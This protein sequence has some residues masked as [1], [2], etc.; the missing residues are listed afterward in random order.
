MDTTAAALPG[1]S[2]APSRV[3]AGRTQCAVVGGG[4]LG[5]ALAAALRGSGRSVSGPHGRGADVADADVVVLCVPDAAI[6][7]AA[8]AARAS[9]PVALLVHCS[10]ATG[11]AALGADGPRGSL[12]PLVGVPAGTGPEGLAG[13]PCAV[14]GSGDAELALLRELAG[15]IG[16]R[17]FAVADEDRAAYH[18]AASMAAN[19]LVTLEGAAERL[20]GTAGVGRERLV[21]LVR[22]AVE[23]WAASGA[24]EALTGPVARGDVGTVVAQRRAVAGRTPEL[25]GLFDALVPTTARTARAAHRA[26]GAA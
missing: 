16:M 11:L 18:A 22:G 3:V 19:F 7:G 25:L 23:H 26:E 15:S 5:T 8:R 17:P 20:A 14:A 10:G 4:R 9:A 1:G 6:P 21:P 2:I 13:A 12:H 24:R